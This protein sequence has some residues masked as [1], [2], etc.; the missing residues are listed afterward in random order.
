MKKIIAI[1]LLLVGTASISDAQ[2]AYSKW[3]TAV[4]GTDG[5]A[6]VVPAASFTTG[7]QVGALM[8][9]PNAVCKGSRSARITSILI[10]DTTD[11]NISWSLVLFKGLPAGTFTSGSVPDPN[12]DQLSKLLP[13]VTL[14]TT[15]RQSF[16][17]N[18]YASLS[19]ANSAGFSGV[20]TAGAPQLYAVL[21]ANGSITTESGGVVPQIEIT[22][23]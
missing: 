1:L 6:F 23:D 20:D 8:R 10:P 22:C 18:G 7:Q 9:F 12:D 11:T 16:A 3:I 13:F 4:N 5:A 21:R 19:S 15:D 17:D 14:E 2:Y